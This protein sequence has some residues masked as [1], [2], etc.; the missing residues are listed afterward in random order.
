MS[1]AS[2]LR[3]ARGGSQHLLGVGGGVG[4]FGIAALL[5][6]SER[7]HTVSNHMAAAEG[8][9]SKP[10]PAASLKN[11]MHASAH[12]A[13]SSSSEGQHEGDGAK[14]QKKPCRACTDFRSWSK[15][16]KAKSKTSA[17]AGEEGASGAHSAGR[18]PCRAV[19][20]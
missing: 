8:A 9:E 10:S 2:A 1:L 5:Y 3:A 18:Y 19:S 4:L 16:Q 6:G 13:S 17:V 11:P 7:P 14:P 12:E 15:S 20:V